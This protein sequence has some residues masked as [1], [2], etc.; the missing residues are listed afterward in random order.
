MSQEAG[1]HNIQGK[2]VQVAPFNPQD[3]I[4]KENSAWAKIYT[5]CGQALEMGPREAVNLFPQTESPEE[6]VLTLR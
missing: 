2:D 1:A 4:H 3:I 6:P 5:V